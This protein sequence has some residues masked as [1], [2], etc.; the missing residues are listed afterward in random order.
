LKKLPVV[1]DVDH[2][3]KII[4]LCTSAAENV[5]V[6]DRNS[7]PTLIHCSHFAALLL[8]LFFQIVSWSGEWCLATCNCT[9][10]PSKVSFICSC[11][12]LITIYN[13]SHVVFSHWQWS[14]LLAV[15]WLW[16]YKNCF[17]FS[18]STNL[19]I[20]YYQYEHFCYIIVARAV[21]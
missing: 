7:V 1:A 4:I 6:D 10:T 21:V 19:F 9:C 11:H 8:N 15:T 20:T 16:H 12:S 14:S 5:A 2:C 17:N 3:N 13:T 18:L